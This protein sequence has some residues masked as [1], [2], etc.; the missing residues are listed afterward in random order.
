MPNPITVSAERTVPASPERVYAFL[1]DYREARPRILTPNYVDYRV[2]EPAPGT[3]VERDTTSSLVT[4][5][6]VMPAPNDQSIVRVV[7]EWQG[8]SGIRGFFERTFAPRGLRRIY[9]DLLERLATAV[10]RS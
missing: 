4:T 7:T 9:D 5:W 1:S 2:E 8:G 3:L 6:R 10:A